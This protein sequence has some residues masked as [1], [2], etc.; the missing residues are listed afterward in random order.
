META[1]KLQFEEIIEIL[2]TKLDDEAFDDGEE[3]EYSIER[4]NNIYSKQK[5]N[6]LGLGPIVKKPEGSKGGSGQGSDYKRIYHFVDHDVY[7]EISG[8]YSS[9][10]GVDFSGD[11][12]ECSKEVRPYQEMITVYK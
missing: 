6:E 5:Y 4:F 10:E 1:K 3:Y 8:F 11:W 9:Y 2:K 12:E 7:V